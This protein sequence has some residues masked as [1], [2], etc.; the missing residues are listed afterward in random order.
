MTPTK[1]EILADLSVAAVGVATA[2][3]PKMVPV[4]YETIEWHALVAVLGM[5]LIIMGI[6]HRFYKIKRERLE[7]DVLEKEAE[8][9]D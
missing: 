2:V 7:C 5:T 3:N 9:E 6:I 4:F 1:S 8:N